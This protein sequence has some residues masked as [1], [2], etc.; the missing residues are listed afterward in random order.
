MKGFRVNPDFV[1][2]D[3]V[4]LRSLFDATHA[5]AIQK[6][7]NTL[8]QHAQ[9]FIRR[10]PFLCIGTQNLDGKADVSPRG[11]P[12]GFVKILDE[13]T[14]AIPDRPG[15]NRLDSLVNILANPSVGLLFFIPG[16]D[17]TLRVNGR[18]SLVNDPEL[19]ASMKVNDRT[20]KLAI[21]VEVSEVFIHC[22]KALRR[23]HLWNPDHFQD[24]NEMPSLMKFILDETTGAPS[25]KDEMRKMDDNLEEAYQRTLY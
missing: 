18:A 23:S 20:P 13:L 12:V 7:Q 11:D 1:I 6:S 8:G 24:R 2:R 14:L 3:E 4:S 5:L 22:A 19:L 21:V 15:N 10:S 9:E 16:Y 25:D 17:D